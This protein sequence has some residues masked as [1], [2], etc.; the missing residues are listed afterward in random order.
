M[1]MAETELKEVKKMKEKQRMQYYF[2][3][4]ITY[5]EEK[6]YEKSL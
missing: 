5:I 3:K 4:Y 1:E 6:N 2:S